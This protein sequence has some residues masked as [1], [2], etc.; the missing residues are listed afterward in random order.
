MIDCSVGGRFGR[1]HKKMVPEVPFDMKQQILVLFIDRMD[2][3]LSFINFLL[4]VNTIK[5]FYQEVIYP[6]DFKDKLHL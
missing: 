5:I 4:N 3:E 2:F 6:N 1:E